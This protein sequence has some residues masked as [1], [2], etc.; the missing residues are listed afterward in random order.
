MF[1]NTTESQRNI[2][3]LVVDA[4]SKPEVPKYDVPSMIRVTEK[5]QI[6]VDKLATSITEF[7]YDKGNNDTT[8]LNKLGRSN[9][10]TDVVNKRLTSFERI[11]QEI[12]QSN[13]D[14]KVIDPPEIKPDTYYSQLQHGV[15]A[16]SNYIFKWNESK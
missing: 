3:K 10:V 9:E 14:K 5:K 13:V 8:T 15:N 7:K 2:N 6:P 4:P 1:K 11:I 16:I 12:K